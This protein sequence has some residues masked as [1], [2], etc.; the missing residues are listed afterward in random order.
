M[1]HEKALI[2]IFFIF[3]VSLTDGCIDTGS[4]NEDLVSDELNKLMPEDAVPE[5]GLETPQVNVTESNESNESDESNE[6]NE[7]DESITFPEIPEVPT[8]SEENSSA[9]YPV[10]YRK[11]SLNFRR[12]IGRDEKIGGEVFNI[13]GKTSE[14][15]I[16]DACAVFNHVNRNW[17]YRY[18]KNS[19]FFFGASQTINSGYVGD[20][21]DYSI[22]MSA[23]LKNM[24]FNTR[25]VTT[26]NTT[27]EG[28]YGHAYPELYIG[29]DLDTANRIMDYV[30]ERYPFAESIWYSERERD[31]GEKEYWLNFDW[32]GSNGYRHPGGKY[33]EGKSVIY[34]PNGL[35]EY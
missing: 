11:L 14:Y 5:K 24:G 10:E 29:D 15:N 20:C 22:V 32:S 27:S 6:S 12:A 8:Y 3:F 34:Y 9:V 28:I 18:E 35:V 19:E 2:F 4:L 33:F 23:L 31:D 25:I 7:S 17:Q 16:E 26:Y 21:D 30:A 1:V 13:T